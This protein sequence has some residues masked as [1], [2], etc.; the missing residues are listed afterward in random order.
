MGDSGTPRV[1]RITAGVM[2][3]M[4]LVLVLFSAFYIAAEADHDC[5]GE[6]C[7]ICRCV[8]ACENTL[9]GAGGAAGARSADSPVF[10]LLL[11]AA[12][13]LSAAARDTLVTGKVRLNN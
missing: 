13:V 3:L 6:D 8:R 4:M 9:H 12:F 1:L 7:L 2:G 10:L 11:A 5:S